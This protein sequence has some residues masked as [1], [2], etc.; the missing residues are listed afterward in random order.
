ML[1]YSASCMAVSKV[2]YD[3]KALFGSKGTLRPCL[4]VRGITPRATSPEGLFSHAH[5]IPH[6]SQGKFLQPFGNRQQG[7]ETPTTEAT[8]NQ[9]GK[10]Q[11]TSL[12]ISIIFEFSSVQKKN[13]I[14]LNIF[15]KITTLKTCHKNQQFQTCRIIIIT[16]EHNY[17]LLHLVAL[18]IHVIHKIFGLTQE[19][20]YHQAN[21]LAYTKTRLH[22]S[23][24]A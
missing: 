21:V 16:Q 22:Y 24:Q 20:L 8:R 2:I 9:K 12:R 5:E 3:T 10:N 14:L 11:R 17:S 18:I 4:V 13:Q 6:Q 23:L 19:I 7:E 1:C 15:K